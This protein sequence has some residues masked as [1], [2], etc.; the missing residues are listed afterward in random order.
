MSEEPKAFA[1]EPDGMERLLRET[2][3]AP[4]PLL[5]PNFERNLERKMNADPPRLT[6]TGQRVLIIYALA[7]LVISV[8]AMRLAEVDLPW[9]ALA[10]TAPVMVSGTLVWALRIRQIR[11]VRER[12]QR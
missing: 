11:P 3:S 6:S 4:A 8:L 12:R 9:I 5:P 10:I 2:M 1:D 7:A